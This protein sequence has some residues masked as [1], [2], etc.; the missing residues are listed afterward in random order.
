MRYCIGNGKGT[1]YMVVF[2]YKYRSVIHNQHGEP[3]MVADG[4][5]SGDFFHGFWLQTKLALHEKSHES[6][7][8]TITHVSVF[9][10]GVLIVLFQRYAGLYRYI[11]NGN[12]CHR[13][14]GEAGK[15]LPMP[16]LS[17]V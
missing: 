13:S 2:P 16:L 6:I 15:K 7:L 1:K 17:Y 4:V 3:T 10:F 5:M 8:L 14:S 11:I 12:A 9:T